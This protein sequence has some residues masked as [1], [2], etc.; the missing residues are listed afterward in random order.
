[1]SKTDNY[2]IDKHNN[3]Y[4]KIWKL[5]KIESWR[6]SY[7]IWKYDFDIIL[8]NDHWPK[9][10]WVI[11]VIENGDVKYSLYHDT[12]KECKIQLEVMENSPYLIE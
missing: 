1:M 6:Y 4:K 7:K 11:D 3:E 10:E 9:N 5:R 12:L 2:I 8:C